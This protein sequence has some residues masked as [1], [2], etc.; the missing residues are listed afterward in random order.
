VSDDFHFERGA[1]EDRLV[2]TGRWNCA[3]EA[4]VRLPTTTGLTLVEIR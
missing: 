2:V 3:A 4:A 1:L